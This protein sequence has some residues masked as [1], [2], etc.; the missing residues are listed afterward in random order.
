[1][2]VEKS[3]AEQER[4]KIAMTSNEVPAVEA[5]NEDA[6]N[7]EVNENEE[8]GENEATANEEASDKIEGQIEQSEK[9]EEELEAEKSAAKTA[10]EKAKIQKRIDREVAKRKK[11]EEENEELR[12]QL[13][14]KPDANLTEEEIEKRSNTKAEQ[15]AAE[16][17]FVK[18]SNRLAD[19][20]EKLDPKFLEK[21][22][23]CAKDI[24]PIPSVMVGILGD[25]DN[26]AA[27]LAKLADDVDDY[28]KYVT[29]APLKMGVELTKLSEKM[30]AE[31]K[32]KPKEV[33]KVPAPNT[34]IGGANRSPTQ[35]NDKMD[36]D[37]WVATRNKELAAKGKRF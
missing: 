22:A 36:M 6:G 17:E 37:T 11:L 9:T 12:R 5:D 26:G 20:A 1:M 8:A 3:A 27:V 7:E 16:R 18:T 13:A 32:P 35:L 25:L 24:A 19:D 30:L 2:N 29:M 14:A 15:K 10:A 33:S 23:E 34:P 4:E 28:E 31:K 21:I